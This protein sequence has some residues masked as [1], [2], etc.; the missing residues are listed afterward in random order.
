MRAVTTPHTPGDDAAQRSSGSVPPPS[1]GYHWPMAASTQF[2]Y[3]DATPSLLKSDF[4]AFLR[5][6]V[7]YAVK[8]LGADART[9]AAT[10]DVE[11]LGEQ[12][13]REV[14]AAEEL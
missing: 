10:R 12:T 6:A 5:D 7:D 2:L 13:E 1:N 3:G 9:A 8:V 14:A 11:R 4:I